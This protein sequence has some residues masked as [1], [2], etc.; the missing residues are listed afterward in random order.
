[1]EYKKMRE[2]THDDFVKPYQSSGT[3][4]NGLEVYNEVMDILNRIKEDL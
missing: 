4:F 2:Y 1:M 3:T